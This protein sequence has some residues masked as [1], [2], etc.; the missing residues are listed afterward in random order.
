MNQQNSVLRVV[1][2]LFLAL[3]ACGMSFYVILF[4]SLMVMAV[5]HQANPA[6]T[7][8]LQANLKYFVVPLSLVV[9]AAVFVATL[10]RSGRRG[11]FVVEQRPTKSKRP[12]A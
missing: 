6:T 11:R 9:G 4:L 2:S 7:P 12:A 10:S 3:I 5:T 8:S 1:F